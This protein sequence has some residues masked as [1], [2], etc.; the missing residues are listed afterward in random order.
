MQRMVHFGSGYTKLGKQFL[1]CCYDGGRSL[2]CTTNGLDPPGVKV[3]NHQ[4]VFTMHFK[5]VTGNF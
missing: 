5:Q 4:V 3:N 1:Q 2:G